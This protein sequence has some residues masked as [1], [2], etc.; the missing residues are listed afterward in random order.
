ML[1]KVKNILFLNY[2]PRQNFTLWPL[3]KQ[4]NSL[5]RQILFAFDAAQHITVL[6]CKRLVVYLAILCGWHQKMTTFS[7]QSTNKSVRMANLNQ[8]WS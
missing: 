6:D 3:V 8:Y 5:I 1:E 7:P 4:M 2:N